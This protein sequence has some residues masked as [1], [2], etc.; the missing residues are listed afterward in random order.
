M[1]NKVV[2]VPFPFDDLTQTKVR[3][4]VC[5]TDVIRP[6]DHVVLAFV[7][8]AVPTNPSTTDFIIANGDADFLQTGLKVSSA[9]RLHRLVTVS[10]SLVKDTWAV[11]RRLNVRKSTN[12]FAF[13]STYE[14]KTV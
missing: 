9:I 12:G 14:R 7:T 2:L 4:A 13:Y 5:L 10:K 8:S 6:H 11:C 1:N 3:P